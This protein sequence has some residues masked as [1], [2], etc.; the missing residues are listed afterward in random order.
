[1][2]RNALLIFVM[3]ALAISGCR[4]DDKLDEDDIAKNLQGKWMIKKT[5][6]VYYIDN[7]KDDE[8]TETD[9][10]SSDYLEF[11]ADGTGLYSEEG[12]TDPF[13]YKVN[14]KTITIAEGPNEKHDITIKS[15]IGNDAVLVEEYSETYQGKVHKTVVETTVKK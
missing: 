5:Y 6:E 11:K 12:D 7:V 3:A 8:E 1:M 2:K 4:K 9:Y 10:G 15:L 14:G 13:T